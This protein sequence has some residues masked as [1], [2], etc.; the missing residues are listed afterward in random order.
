MLFSAARWNKAENE[1]QF[2]VLTHAAPLTG[3]SCQMSHVT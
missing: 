1:K 2:C 3:V